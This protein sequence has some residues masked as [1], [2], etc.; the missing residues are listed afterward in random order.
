MPLPRRPLRLH[1]VLSREE[2]ERLIQNAASFLH[3]IWLLILYGTRIRREEL[4]R[5]K[6]G[7][8]DSG[9]MLIHI[10]QG[11]GRKDRDVM[12][13]PR[14]LAELRDYWRR[15]L[16]RPKTYLFPNKGGQQNGDS[17]MQAKSFVVGAVAPI[18]SYLISVCMVRRGFAS[19]NC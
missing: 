4:V 6:V 10:R 9:R 19:E 8:I 3:R 7:D 12:L 18:R 17:P 2:V 15:A 11:K 1:E 16:P 13:G 14:L 5:L